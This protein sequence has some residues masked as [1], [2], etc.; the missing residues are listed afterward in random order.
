M[1]FVMMIFNDDD[2]DDDVD[3]DD[4]DDDWNIKNLCFKLMACY[5]IAHRGHGLW[6]WGL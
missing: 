6:S 4:D 1:T 2:D 3:D 5:I